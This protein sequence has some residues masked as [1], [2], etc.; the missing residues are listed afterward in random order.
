VK[1]N[2][3]EVQNLPFCDFVSHPSLLFDRRFE[4]PRVVNNGKRSFYGLENS[5]GVA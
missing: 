1:D 2:V 3:T 5:L 4:P